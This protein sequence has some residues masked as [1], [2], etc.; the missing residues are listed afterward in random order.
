MLVGETGWVTGRSMPQGLSCLSEP[1][2]SFSD[3]SD[4]SQG[5]WIAKD[6][7]LRVS[8]QRAV[9]EKLLPDALLAL[10]TLT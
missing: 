7:Q 5:R 3:V 9:N 1:P 10:Q 6:L 2:D 8:M 4:N